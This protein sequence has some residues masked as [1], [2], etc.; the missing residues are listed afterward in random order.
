MSQIGPFKQEKRDASLKSTLE[1]TGRFCKVTSVRSLFPPLMNLKF[2]RAE[3]VKTEGNSV[4]GEIFE[5]HD[6]AS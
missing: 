1:T 2:S 3:R 5:I 4:R 6:V